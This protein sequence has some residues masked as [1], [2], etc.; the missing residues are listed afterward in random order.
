MQST[1]RR[2]RLEVRI[3]ITRARV[4]QQKKAGRGKWP[5]AY[6]SHCWPARGRNWSRHSSAEGDHGGVRVV[7]GGGEGRV[8]NT[9]RDR[10]CQSV[11]A[12]A[13]L[14]VGWTQPARTG[15]AATA[16]PA[17]V[18]L[19][20]MQAEEVSRPRPKGRLA[21]RSSGV[22]RQRRRA[23]IGARVSVCVRACMRA[24]LCAY[25]WWGPGGG[26]GGDGMDTGARQVCLYV[27]SA[28][29]TPH[30][31]C[32]SCDHCDDVVHTA[33]LFRTG[34]LSRYCTRYQYQV[35]SGTVPR[36]TA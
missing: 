3:A 30:R 24:D 5:P 20:H 12:A 27:R 34:I 16:S 21:D 35:P 26:G 22:G 11:A 10:F 33:V 18:V 32:T 31:T 1:R 2:R 23:S 8:D 7:A 36:S 15:R 17:R 13:I 29:V 19:W 4:L 14:R 6:I 9:S 28:C 25:K